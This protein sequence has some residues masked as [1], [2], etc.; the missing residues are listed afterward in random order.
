MVINLKKTKGANKTYNSFIYPNTI[1]LGSS[2]IMLQNTE[3]KSGLCEAVIT[4]HKEKW[5]E[6]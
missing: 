4:L 2:K 3:E 5:L 1:N 6:H